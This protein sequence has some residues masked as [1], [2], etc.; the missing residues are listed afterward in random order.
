MMGIT[1]RRRRGGVGFPRDWFDR[2]REDPFGSL[3]SLVPEE[4]GRR[5]PSVDIAEDDTS[6]R[7]R[8]EIPGMSREDLDV[9]YDSGVLHIAGEKK[10]ET[11]DARVRECRYGYFSRDIPLGEKLQWDKVSAQYRDGVLS[12][13]IPKSEGEEPKGKQIKVD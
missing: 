8:A 3:R 6:L 5:E 11:G 4:W 9:T 10:E 13:E 12:I 1:P 2:A 7:V